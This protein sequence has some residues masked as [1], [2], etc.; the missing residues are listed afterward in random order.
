MPDPSKRFRV[1]FS[2]AGEKRGFVEKVAALLAGRFGQ[3]A[4]LYD[5][6]H[7][8]EFARW[9]LGM[10]LPKLYGQQSDLVVPVLCPRYDEK[11]WTGWEWVHIYGLLTKADGHRVMP[12]RFEHANADGLAPTAGFIELDD[13]TP[14]QA[15]ALILQ[16]LAQNEG[17]PRD[18]YLRPAGPAP[19]RP[20]ALIPNNLPRPQPFFGRE[21]E[22]KKIAA[23]LSPKARGWGALID[24]PGGIGKT[25]LAVRAAELV[26]AG[27]F[28]RIIFLSS[29]EREL[30]A[31]GQRALGHFVL[32]GYLDML[33][34]IAGQI[35]KSELTKLPDAERTSAILT[36]LGEMEALLLLDNLETLP[37]G[38]RDQLFAFLSNLPT[39]CSAIVTSRRRA[40]A[41]ATTVRLDQLDWPAAQALLA[42]LAEDNERLARTTDAERRALYEET[43]GNP[44]LMRWI[45][46]QLGL[47]RCHTIAAALDLLRAAPAGNSPLEFIFG[48]LLDTFTGNETKVLAALAHFTAPMAVKFIAELAGLHDAAAQ[49]ALSDLSSRA[50]V[51]PDLEERHFHLVPMVADFLRRKRPEAVAE[52]GS[53]LER[54]AYALIVENGYNKHDRFPVLDAAWPTVAPALPLFLAG[55]N[56]RLQTVCD[57]LQDF[58]N[59]TGRWD[60]KLSLNQQAEARALAAGDLGKAGWC[61]YQAGW[62]YYLRQQAE[63]VLAC[64]GRAAAHWAQAQAGARER[65]MAIQLRGNA[66]R[67]QRDYPAAIEAYREVLALDRSI[68]AES[69]DV[70]IDLNS[71]A[72]AEQLAG[73]HAA[74]ER[75]YGEALRV[76]RAAGYAEGVAS[77][78]GNLAGLALDRAEWPAAEALAREAL[79]LAEGVGRQQ[80]IAGNCRRLAKALARQGKAADGLPYAQR[81]VAL[82]TRLG[83]PDLAY[84]LATLRECGG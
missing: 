67:L 24:G 5:K 6:Y 66:L 34:A 69:A 32:P 77:Y 72:A 54:R 44:L 11:R 73:D 55:P 82:Y 20:G 33:N 74:A 14:E 10:H 63:E 21:T 49:G 3:E 4:I 75:D 61:A 50:L 38:D 17:L 70:A 64:A 31:D 26:P 83:S 43:G 81:A 47:G 23:A 41:Q 39:S 12:C 45:S 9:D 59:F 42:V 56:P 13:K 37:E 68:A 15:A 40:D 35:H 46:G 62:V 57:A 65:G 28:Q 29:K 2:F 79:P 51:V 8:A 52:T 76:A 18:H 58:L 71:L 1:A 30:T 22:L 27:R 25:A 84:A 53:R 48:D 80:L 19:I 78:T 16:R 36:A 60:E 7:E